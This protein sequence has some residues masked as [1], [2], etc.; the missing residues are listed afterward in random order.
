MVG[1][2]RINVTLDPEHSALLTRLAK[3]ALARAML[4]TPLEEADPQPR[5]V[6]ATLDSVPGAY[7]RVVASL[8]QG[9]AGNT[10]GLDEL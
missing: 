10:I 3:G 1:F 8:D 7:D 4:S 9:R 2:R 5:N 6:V